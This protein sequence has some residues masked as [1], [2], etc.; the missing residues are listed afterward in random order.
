MFLNSLILGL[1]S[2]DWAKRCWEKVTNGVVISQFGLKL[3]AVLIGLLDFGGELCSGRG[4][5][6]R[7]KGKAIKKNMARDGPTKMGKEG[8][9]T[10]GTSQKPAIFLLS[11][12]SGETQSQ[13]KNDAGRR[14]RGSGYQLS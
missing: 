9:R 13:S 6:S 14:K 12:W 10:N 8:S 7:G 11:A 3:G 5:K 2:V 1:T 4:R